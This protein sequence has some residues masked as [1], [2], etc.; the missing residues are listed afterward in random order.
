MVKEVIVGEWEKAGMNFANISILLVGE[1][2]QIKT[3]VEHLGADAVA[4]RLL[5]LRRAREKEL[6]KQ[7][8]SDAARALIIQRAR[9]RKLSENLYLY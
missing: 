3:G 7:K 4:A 6:A 9:D 8:D 2:P 5:V 1:L